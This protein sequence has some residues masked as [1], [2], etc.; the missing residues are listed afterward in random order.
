MWIDHVTLAGRDATELLDLARDIGI[1]ARRAPDWSP[2]MSR[3]VAVLGNGFLEM[4]SLRDPALA[5]QSVW[6]QALMRFLRGGAGLFRV[7]LGV[8]DLS[9]FIIDKG[10]SGVHWW[11][12]MADQITGLSNQPL[13]VRL[14]QIDPTLPW[15][16]EY[17][18]GRPP[19][20]SDLPRIEQ[21]IVQ[22]P[23]PDVTR[24][25]YQLMLGRGV[26]EDTQGSG[27]F[28]FQRG[29]ETAY[30]ALALSGDRGVRMVSAQDGRLRIQRRV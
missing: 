1:A 20:S 28:D 25:H 12:P 15:L 7:V 27:L 29:P 21:V 22:S 19:A 9:G 6:G 8:D 17:S 26:L 18:S 16:V 11:P 14:T 10:R 24:L 3:H 23:H 13:P 5:R 4:V 30:A 2:G